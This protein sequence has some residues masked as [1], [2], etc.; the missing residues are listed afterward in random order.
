MV[1]AVGV[2]QIGKGSQKVED[3]AIHTDEGGERPE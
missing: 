1:A 3:N 2:D